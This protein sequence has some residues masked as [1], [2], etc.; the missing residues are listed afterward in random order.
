MFPRNN[1]LLEQ[2]SGSTPSQ[3]DSIVQWLRLVPLLSCG[4]REVT[5]ANGSS[6]VGLA[7]V[8]SGAPVG[9]GEVR[10]DDGTAFHTS[11]MSSIPTFCS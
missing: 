3:S 1:H 5:T 9:H 10:A 4:T 6:N 8:R 7:R 2:V 11:G